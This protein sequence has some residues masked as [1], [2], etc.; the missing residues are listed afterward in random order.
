[1]SIFERTAGI[2]RDKGIDK[3]VRAEFMAK[4]FPSEWS[5][6]C[7]GKRVDLLYTLFRK[8]KQTK[9][10]P[11]PDAIRRFVLKQLRQVHRDVL[12]C[13]QMPE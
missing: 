10:L 11:K 12:E 7:G 9:P 3:E 2:L 6:A 1:M 8:G 5:W 13:L 4:G